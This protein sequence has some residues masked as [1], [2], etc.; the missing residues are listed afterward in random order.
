MKNATITPG[1]KYYLLS[2][3]PETFT[4]CEN[5]VQTIYIQKK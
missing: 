3:E 4:Q 5:M 2:R 1:K